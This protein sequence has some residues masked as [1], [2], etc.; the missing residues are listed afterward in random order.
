[1]SGKANAVSITNANGLTE[2]DL[3]HTVEQAERGSLSIV[4]NTGL[5]SLKA[6][7]IA[8]AASLT[9]TGNDALSTIS[10]DAL[11]TQGGA[12]T[13]AASVD[14]SDNDL[15]AT[16]AELTKEAV[17]TAK[18]EGKFTSTSGMSDLEAYLTAAAA[19]YASKGGSVYAS[20]DTLEKYL[21]IDDVA[22]NSAPFT[23]SS[24][25]G[26]TKLELAYLSVGD[27]V[28]AITAGGT[29]AKRSFVVDLSSGDGAFQIHANGVI[30][31]AA[32]SPGT[33]AALAALSIASEANV[34]TANAVGVALSAAATARG[35]ATITLGAIGSSENSPTSASAI[36][37]L[38]AADSFLKSNTVKLTIDGNSYTYSSTTAS[39]TAATLATNL[40]SGFNGAFADAVEEYTL[41]AGSGASIVVT[42]RDIGSDG[43]G[44]NISLTWG[45]TGTASDT[46]I[47]HVINTA[48]TSDNKTVA[49]T[50]AVLVTFEASSTGSDLSEIGYPTKAM[51]TAVKSV[52]VS[53]TV[54]TSTVTE[55]SSTAFSNSNTASGV[56]TA[57]NKYP[58]ESRNDVRNPHDG[59]TLRAESGTK[60]THNQIAWL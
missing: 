43:V 32:G 39:M 54:G 12:A 7:K 31:D 18:A 10:F 27:F 55:L 8:S 38:T 15:T 34:A 41:S 35:T 17:G 59:A 4:D 1:M 56:E 21:D 49:S 6:D 47:G 60:N 20:F 24:K 58:T 53:V 57:T 51:S 37:N 22:D 14:V 40:I 42:S 26:E 50:S 30:V 11:K 48:S 25:G 46:S 19:R 29:K 33:N 3:A 36:A 16:E 2:L 13:A 45:K 5:T 9:I 44:Q 23:W 52:K 28:S